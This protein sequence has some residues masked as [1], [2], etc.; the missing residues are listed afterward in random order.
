MPRI[1]KAIIFDKLNDPALLKGFPLD[2]R[3]TYILKL[4]SG[5]LVIANG[6]I[7]FNKKQ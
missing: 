3:E 4:M 7:T 1:Q 6:K 2:A 5:D